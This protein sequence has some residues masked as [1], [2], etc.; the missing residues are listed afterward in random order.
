MAKFLPEKNPWVTAIGST[1]IAF[2]VIASPWFLQ[3]ILAEF[4]ID[5]G[6]LTWVTLGLGILGFITVV[7]LIVY[8]AKYGD[9]EKSAP[10]K[11]LFGK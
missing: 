1:T 5:W 6:W 8:Q 11:R 10:W 4:N 2:L 7:F 3:L 9:I